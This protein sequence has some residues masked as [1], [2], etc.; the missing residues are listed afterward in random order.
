MTPKPQVIKEKNQQVGLH[1]TK[2]LLHS[3]RNKEYENQP[4]E[5]EK[6]FANHISNKVLISMIYKEF[7]QLNNNNNNK[8]PNNLIKDKWRN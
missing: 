6:I 5:Q 7:I 3:K 1:Q 8:T 2:K 4:A